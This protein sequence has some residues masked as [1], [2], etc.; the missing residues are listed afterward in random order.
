MAKKE[1]LE[2]IDVMQGIDFKG[3]R[4]KRE[5]QK[6]EFNKHYK[7]VKKRNY[8]LALW[9]LIIVVLFLSIIPIFKNIKPKE[10]KIEIKEAEKTIS[11]EASEPFN[12]KLCTL[13]TV[14]CKKENL[15]EISYQI[16]QEAILL[17]IDWKIAVAIAK[18]ETGHYTSQAFKKLN[19]VGGNFGLRDGK[20]QLLKFDT[21]EDG[22][23]F[24]VKNLKNN[25]FNKGLTTLEK[26]QQKYAPI[27][28]KND[29]SKLNNYW[30]DGVK[31]IYEE[32][33]V[34]E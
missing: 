21:L 13:K 16:K 9:I 25:Y 5:Q 30:L 7:V 32:L 24:F 18:W 12:D 23:K 20:Y 10:E 8:K 31:K 26:I 27:G 1:R 15:D 29:P 6:A 14:T 22:V 11:N 17:E 3:N 2:D 33:E 19:N 34:K 4:I 28:A